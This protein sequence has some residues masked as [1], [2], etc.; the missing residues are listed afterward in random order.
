MDAASTI[1][2]RHCQYRGIVKE[3]ECCEVHVYQ[4][5]LVGGDSDEDAFREKKRLCCQCGVLLQRAARTVEVQARWTADQTHT[6][7][8][9]AHRLHYNLRRVPKIDENVCFY[10]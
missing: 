9:L 10:F 7:T 2:Q 6:R 4:L 8:V 1:T 5:V 3:A